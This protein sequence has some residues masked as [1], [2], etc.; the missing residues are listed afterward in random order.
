MEPKDPILRTILNINKQLNIYVKYILTLPINVQNYLKKSV[1]STIMIADNLNLALLDYKNLLQKIDYELDQR[2]FVLAKK[3]NNKLQIRLQEIKK[4]K[5]AFFLSINTINNG[6]IPNISGLPD[7][8]KQFNPILSPIIVVADPDD[9]ISNDDD[10][11]VIFIEYVKGL[12]K[13]IKTEPMDEDQ[14]PNYNDTYSCALPEPPIPATSVPK[15]ENI[16]LQLSKNNEKLSNIDKNTT[17]ALIDIIDQLKKQ[18]QVND[19]QLFLLDL[20]IKN[21]KDALLS[22]QSTIQNVK[23]ILKPSRKRLSS[24]VQETDTKI[25]KI[26]ELPNNEMEF[27]FYDPDE[28]L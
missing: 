2:H 25:T 14:F 16:T 28:I 1:W 11:D 18:N 10:D 22:S 21:Y 5:D 7:Y 24:I 6:N 8:S 23:P 4:Y 19:R 17:K 13:P 12:P 9:A 26:D 3:Y 20:L 15:L 27:E